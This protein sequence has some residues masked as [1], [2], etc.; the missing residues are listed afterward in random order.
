M[1]AFLCEATCPFLPLWVL[2]PEPRHAVYPAIHTV[3]HVTLRAHLRH[4]NIYDTS[5]RCVDAEDSVIFH[6]PL[7]VSFND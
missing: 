3:C 1:H 4:E 2:R 5:G 7:H 6:T